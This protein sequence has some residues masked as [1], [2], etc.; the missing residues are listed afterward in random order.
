MARRGEM[1]PDLVGP[2]CLG[3]DLEEGETIKPFDHLPSGD[4]HPSLFGASGHSFSFTRM[5]SNRRIDQAFILAELTIGDG[6]ID[7]FHCAVFELLGQLM[8]GLIIFGN[9]HH[10]RRILI[11]TMDD[12]R[13]QGSI[14]P[15]K[16]FTMMEKCVD[17]RAGRVSSGWMNDHSWRLIDDNDRRVLI[18]D[19]EGKRLGFNVERPGLRNNS[20]Y[21]IARFHPHTG[22]RRPLVQQDASRID[23]FL[24]LRAGEIEI[25]FREELIEAS[26]LVPFCYGDGEMFS[27]LKSILIHCMWIDRASFKDRRT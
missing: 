6:Q 7:L 14:N 11:Q 20:R 25:G 13:P 3:E 17:Q 27:Y 19:V 22:F 15:A 26:S 12:P 21:P 23:Q 8:I 18:E 24:D 4:G 1:D 16:V 10:A 9:D 5:S 2:T